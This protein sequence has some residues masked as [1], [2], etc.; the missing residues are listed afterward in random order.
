MAREMPGAGQNA[1]DQFNA[2]F[3]NAVESESQTQGRR[4]AEAFSR[5]HGARLSTAMKDE[6]VSAAASFGDVAE[7]EMAR[8]GDNTGN[9][10]SDSFHRSFLSRFASHLPGWRALMR[11]G[12]TADA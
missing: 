10:Y 6:A 9:T 8:V 1:A 2:S 3:G 12:I 7:P 4:T 5:A 11:D